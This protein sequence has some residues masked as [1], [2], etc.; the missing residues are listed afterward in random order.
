MSLVFTPTTQTAERSNF[1]GL[2]GAYMLIGTMTFSGSYATGGDT[3]TTG[4]N[5]EDLFKILGSGKIIAAIADLRGYT[6][7]WDATAKK[8]KLF[9]AGAELSAG[10]YPAGLTA[11]P[12]PCAFLGR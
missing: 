10:A 11:T 8:L 7:E 12:V 2:D 1:I 5:L 9:N 6:P 3:F 4:K